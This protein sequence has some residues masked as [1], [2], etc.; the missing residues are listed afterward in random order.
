[1]ADDDQ[2]GAISFNDFIISYLKR[3]IETVMSVADVKEMFVSPR[4]T[5]DAGFDSSCFLSRRECQQ[6]LNMLGN[7]SDERKMK[8][9][10]RI[11]D[12]N[13]DD[14]ITLERFYRFLGADVTQRR[15]FGK[16]NT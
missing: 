7:Y 3:N 13:D 8:R 14:E 5:R 16:A 6:L 4:Y 15:Y 12:N 10:M 11:L 1:M 9:T 2:D